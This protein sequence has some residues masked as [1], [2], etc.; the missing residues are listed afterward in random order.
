M[1]ARRDDLDLRCYLVTSGTSRRTVEVAAAAAAA[2]A[3]VV[4]VRAK[5]ASTA[6]LLELVLAVADAV[7]RA[8]PAT[9]VLV[10]DRADVAAAARARGAAVH[11]VHLGQDDLPVADARALLGEDALIGL[12]TGTAELVRAAAPLTPLLDY[13]GAG[14]FR[15]TP[16]KDSGRPPL[17]AEGYRELTAATTLP[18]VAIGDVTPADV[19]GL[20]AAGVAGVALVRAVMDA[21]DPAGVVREVLDGVGER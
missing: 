19:P 8:R 6:A 15:L 10:D 2:G 12:T 13:L 3:G 20:A 21:A 16:T 17:G 1:T 4:Q 18:I 14:P 5:D 11:G 9:T 7:E